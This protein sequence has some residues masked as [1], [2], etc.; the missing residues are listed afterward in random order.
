MNH[1]SVIQIHMLIPEI[2]SQAIL[3]KMSTYSLNSTRY[4]ASILL[5][6]HLA[7]RKICSIVNTAEGSDVKLIGIANIRTGY[8]SRSR[9]IPVTT[10]SHHLLQSGD[11]KEQISV[12][13]LDSLTKFNPKLSKND[14][15]LKSDD[16][17]MMARG[18]RNVATL[19]TNLPEHT[20]AA[21]SFFIVRIKENLVLPEYLVWY[22]N[23]KPVQ[24][25]LLRESGS[26]VHMRVIRRQVLEQ[27]EIPIP[28][29]DTQRHIAL[30]IAAMK[31][32]QVLLSNLAEKRKSLFTG[33]CMKAIGISMQ[34]DQS[35]ILQ[36]LSAESLKNDKDSRREKE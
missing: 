33:V 32:E 34:K 21:A 12:T 1:T 17:L 14:W 24:E 27:T 9:I 13:D 16:I 26:G 31:E 7:L 10:G 15:E 18:T 3:S 6:L 4:T 2:N 23:Q 11:L 5:T 25:Y 8:Q 28:P 19:L 30:V 36:T 22:L 20:V 29:I 35:T